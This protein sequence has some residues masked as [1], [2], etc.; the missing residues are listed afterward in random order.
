MNHIKFQNF[1]KVSI[2]TKRRRKNS[3]SINQNNIKYPV[4]KD[5]S[6]STIEA[7]NKVVSRSKVNNIKDTKTTSSRSF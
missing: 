2:K 6:K 7:L 4:N 1:V 3:P 5:P